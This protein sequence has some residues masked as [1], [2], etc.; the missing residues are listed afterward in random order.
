MADNQKVFQDSLKVLHE[1][2]GG[3][4]VNADNI[5]Q[6]LRFAM[7][8]VEVTELKGTAQRDLALKLV[9]Q[10]IVDAPVSDEKEQLLL[11]LVDSGVLTGTIDLIVDASKGELDVNTLVATGSSCLSICFKKNK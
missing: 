2:M 1:H 9:R 7:E 11:G 5:M 4:E 3:L 10:V 6:V 8:V